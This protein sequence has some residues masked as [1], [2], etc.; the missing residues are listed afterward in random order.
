MPVQTT[1]MAT[2]S[3]LET[4]ASSTMTANKMLT[5]PRGTNQFAV[6]KP[7]AVDLPN[8]VGTSK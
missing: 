1:V 5:S 2:L 8:V 4:P 3:P 6:K 7:Q